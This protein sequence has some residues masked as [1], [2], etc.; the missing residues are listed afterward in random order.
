[1]N[2]TDYSL[3]AAQAI[4][5]TD[6]E[7]NALA[8]LANLTALLYETLDDVNWAGIYLL[9]DGELVLG[10]FQGRAACVRI[11][12]GK[13]VCGTAVAEN[14]VL[15]VADVHSFA[16]HIACDAASESEIVLPLR[17]GEQVVGVLDI[18]SPVR[19]RF[20]EEDETGLAGIAAIFQ[21]V[22]A[23]DPRSVGLAG[24]AG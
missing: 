8:N 11:G 13:G 1:M 21:A 4:A 6:G 15:R 9:R 22:L 7:P 19:G 2:N 17:I 3:L 24:D 18:D 20:S 5:L 16:G 12:V 14:R 10:P 23:A